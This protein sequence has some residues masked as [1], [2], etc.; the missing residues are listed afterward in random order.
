MTI[1]LFIAILWSCNTINPPSENKILEEAEETEQGVASLLSRIQLPEG[2]QI[3]LFA[4]GVENARSMTLSSSGTLYVGTRDAGKVYAIEDTNKDF[5]ADKI[6][7]LA[8][9]LE[10][11]NGVALLNG[12]LYVA[13]YNRI[14]KFPNIDVNLTQPKYEVVTDKYPSKKHHGW[15]YIAFGPDDKLYVPVGAPCNICESDEEIFNTITRIN[16]DGSNLEI[17][18]EGI[19]NT[20]GF[21][22][23]P[24]TGELWFTDNGRDWLGDDKPECELNRAPKEGMHFGYPYCHQGDIEDPKV[25]PGKGCNSYTPPVAKLGPHTAPLGIEFYEGDQFPANYKNQAFIARHGSWNRST[26]IGY[27]LVLAN[28]DVSD[29]FIETFAS[30]WLDKE[31]DEAWGRPVDVEMLADGS[32]LVSDDFANVI[33]RISYKR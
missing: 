27:D 23:H 15:K 12:H 17:V 25:G 19:R 18:Q 28:T 8:E 20:V 4:E 24:E 29:A 6:T 26:K 21:D 1:L 7:V 13:E 11:P 2:F 32:V 9:G 31:A 30:G 10:M 14:I 3:E 22:W 16:P 5:K 33:Y